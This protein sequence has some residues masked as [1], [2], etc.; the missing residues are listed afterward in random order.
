PRCRRTRPG[1]RARALV[2][3]RGGP[4]SRTARAPFDAKRAAAPR[5]LFR[6][7][8]A[9]FRAT[10]SHSLPRL[11]ARSVQRIPAAGGR[12]ART[13]HLKRLAGPF[14]SHFPYT[15]AFA[16]TCGVASRACGTDDGA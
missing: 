14:G 9:P 2:T 16:P 6:R 3:R 8:A 5:L 12:E 10:E 15:E 13:G 11:A 1:S 4:R 7:A